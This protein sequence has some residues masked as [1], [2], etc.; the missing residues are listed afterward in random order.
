VEQKEQ[1]GTADALNQARDHVKTDRFIALYGDD[2]YDPVIFSE[3]MQEQNA[4]AAKEKE[5]WQ[6]YGVFR[7]DDKGYLKDI[8]EKPQH[9]VGKLVNIGVF[10]LQKDIFLYYEKIPQSVRGEY[11][12]TDMISL[13]SRDKAIKVIQTQ[14][15]WMP[16]GYPWHLLD[17][18]KFFIEHIQTDIQ[19][20]VEEGV[21]IKG[22]IILGKGS[23]I[24]TGAYLEGNFIIGENCDI[25]PNCYLRQFVV[26]GDEC[27]IGNAV[28]VKASIFGANVKASHLSYIPD[29]VVGNNV[30]FGGGTIIADL[31]HNQSNIKMIVNGKLID[32]GRRKLGTIVGDGT[33]TAIHTSIY[34][35]RKL[36]SGAWTLPG[37]VVKEDKK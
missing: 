26:L 32:T 24:R 5:E 22:K 7:T 12:V 23:I 36:D 10:M 4:V 33:R 34:P 8:I 3:I 25:G 6:N 2:I 9:F 28:E 15:Y 19:G 17:A 20:T 14:G 1:L 27:K 37:E 13:F 21:T 30:N 16:I 29:S 18:T 31:K 35:G 11:E